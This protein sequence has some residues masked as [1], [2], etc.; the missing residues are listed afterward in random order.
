MSTF[1]TFARLSH[2][3]DPLYR[4]E[5]HL[6]APGVLESSDG[7][8]LID[9]GPHRSIHGLEENLKAA[10]IYLFEIRHILVTH[11]HLDHAGGVGH[12]VAG[13]EDIQVHVHEIGAPHLIDPSR[14]LSSARRIYGDELDAKWGSMR[15]V[16]KEQ[17]YALSSGDVLDFGNR[18]IEVLYTPGH[19]KH[20]VSFVDD[21]SGYAFVGDVAGQ[22]TTGVSYILPVT[23]PPDVDLEAWFESLQKIERTGV[24][25]LFLTHFGPSEEPKDHLQTIKEKLDTWGEEVRRTLRD[26][27]PDASRAEEFL[28]AKHAEM[29][30]LLDEPDRRPYEL[31]GHPEGSWHGLARYWRNT[32]HGD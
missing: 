13:R 23:P 14:L 30:A 15:A 1:S 25:G 5:Q 27:R 10:G 19:A 31:F 2:F 26:D 24:D 17:V 21:Y 20:H 22:K 29:D 8:I 32:N 7:Y 4:G 16:P 28:R 11:I 9:P 12:L 3:V 18:T 6:I